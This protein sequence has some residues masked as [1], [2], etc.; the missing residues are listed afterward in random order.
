[1]VECAPL[2]ARCLFHGLGPTPPSAGIPRLR[3]QMRKRPVEKS[4]VF[5]DGYDRPADDAPPLV[6]VGEHFQVGAHREPEGFATIDATRVKPVRD[7]LT[8]RGMKQLCV[9]TL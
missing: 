7:G 5:D 4:G 1:M 2:C 9:E 3:R 8:W 6:H